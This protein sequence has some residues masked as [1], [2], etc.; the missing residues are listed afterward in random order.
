MASKID[1]INVNGTSYDIDLPLT[2]TPSITGLTVTGNLTVSGTS[3]LADINCTGLTCSGQVTS[4]SVNVETLTA[5]A[6]TVSNA[7]K[8]KSVV[9]TGIAC[10]GQ[11]AAGSVSAQTLTAGIVNVGSTLLIG[12]GI[13]GTSSSRA[14]RFLTDIGSPNGALY[15]TPLSTASSNQTWVLDNRDHNLLLTVSGSVGCSRIQ[16]T[17]GSNAYIALSQGTCT[18]SATR[19]SMFLLNRRFQVVDRSNTLSYVFPSTSGTLALTSDLPHKTT[20]TLSGA[21]VSASNI[22]D[23]VVS[24]LDSSAASWGKFSPVTSFISTYSEQLDKKLFKCVLSALYYQDDQLKGTM[25]A[26]GL[27]YFSK[28]PT[29]DGSAGTF[30]GWGRLISFYSLSDITL[31]NPTITLTEI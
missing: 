14:V 4:T 19:L 27:I 8:L 17:D 31:Q 24:Y 16:A 29:G 12:D 10:T 11:I 7:S 3:D 23:V 22:L 6:L 26:S 9:C 15:L 25:E 1:K 13:V 30:Y 20:L 2:A 21:T 5:G 18:I 28:L